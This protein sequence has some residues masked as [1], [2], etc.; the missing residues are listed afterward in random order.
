MRNLREDFRMKAIEFIRLIGSEFNDVSD[1]ALEQWIEFVGP[2][3]SKKQFGTLYD[4]G[5]ALLVCHF[6]KMHGYGENPLGDMANNAAAMGYGVSSVSEGGSS[7]SFGNSA[8]GNLQDNADLAQTV[9][10]TEYMNLRRKVIV[11][12]HISGERG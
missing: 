7:I 6:M 10:G 2:M 9:Y 1:E 3:V 11:P 12:I 4:Q 8:S 5:L